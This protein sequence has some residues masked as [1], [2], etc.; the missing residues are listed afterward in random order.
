MALLLMFIVAVF[1]FLGFART[2]LA[3]SLTQDQKDELVATTLDRYEQDLINHTVLDIPIYQFFINSPHKKMVSGGHRIRFPLVLDKADGVGWYGL[4]DTFDPQPKRILGWGHATLKQGAGDVTFE[5]LEGWMNSGPGAFINMVTAKVESLEQS[6]KEDLNANAWADGT[7]AGGMEPTGLTGHITSSPTTGT[8]MGFSKVTEFWARHWY[9]DGVTVG[10]HSLTA[11]TGIA[12]V[13]VG[14]IG[15]ISEQFPLIIQRLNNMW[16]STA[17]MENK[18]DIFHITDLQTELWYKDIPFRCPGYDIGVTEGPFNIGIEL[19]HFRGSPIL[20]DTVDNGA[21]AGEWRQV[22]TK[23]Y[24]MYIDQ[25]HFFFWV[26]PRSPYN[27]LRTARY[28]VVR[29]Q[30]VDTY[31]RKQGFLDGIVTWQ[32]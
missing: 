1:I 2:V 5:D 23:Y 18:R 3:Q 10:P 17:K 6:I 26:G 28:L 19:C 27:A 20:S 25:D 32:L 22:N 12:P 7:G 4:G 16:A 21:P 31:P 14:A 24:K 15:D 30:F 9:N 29:F 13:A 8:Y 11:P